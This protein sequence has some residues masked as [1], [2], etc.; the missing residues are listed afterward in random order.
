[1][2]MTREEAIRVFEAWIEHDEKMVYADRLENIEIYKM[3]I[4]ALKA[5]QHGEW[6]P[7]DEIGFVVRCSKCNYETFGDIC[8]EFNFCPH[9]GLPM[10]KEG[11]AE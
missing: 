2:S 1:M 7:T 9:C 5:R 8:E 4:D 11:E 3:A 10:M 6:I